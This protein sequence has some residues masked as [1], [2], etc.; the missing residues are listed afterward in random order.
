MLTKSVNKTYFTESF[1]KQGN[2]LQTYKF[3]KG[4]NWDNYYFVIRLTQ[5]L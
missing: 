1:I 5:D 4:M 2:V 3:G